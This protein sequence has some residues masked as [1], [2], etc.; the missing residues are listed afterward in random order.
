[1]ASS[2]VH[3]CSMQTVLTIF[4]KTHMQTTKNLHLHYGDLSDTSNPTRIIQEVQPAEI[5]NLGAQSH[6]AVSFD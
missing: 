2:A 3:R 1:M 5:Y 4:T 6:V